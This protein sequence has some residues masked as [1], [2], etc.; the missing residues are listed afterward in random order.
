M[1]STGKAFE[2]RVEKMMLSTNMF[3]DNIFNPD[4]NFLNVYNYTEFKKYYLDF[5]T[6][7]SDNPNQIFLFK[8]YPL[9]NVLD[10]KIEFCIKSVLNGVVSDCYVE[11]KYNDVNGTVYQKLMHYFQQHNKTHGNNSNSFMILVYDGKQFIND[12]K[13]KTCVQDIK[14]NHIGFNYRQLILSVT[15]FEQVFIEKLRV[16]TDMTKIFREM[17]AEGY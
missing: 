14:E 15:D 4:K 13:T 7:L 1:G 9:F 12:S 17:K 16:C 11:N 3:S 5:E 10:E 6:Y 2:N 8:N